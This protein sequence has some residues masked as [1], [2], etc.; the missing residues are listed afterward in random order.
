MTFQTI[1]LS[2][3]THIDLSDNILSGKLPTQIGKLS[4]LELLDLSNNL[5]EGEVSE[6]CNG[7]SDFLP[8]ALENCSS[9]RYLELFNKKLTGRLPES[10]SQ[11]QMLEIFDIS[12]NR[13]EGVVRESYFTNLTRLWYFIASMYNLALKVSQNWIP[14]FQATYMEIGGCNIGPLFPKWLQTQKQII[15]LD[16]S[17]GGIEGEVST[18]FWHLSFQFQLLNLSH[19]QFV[20]EVPFISTPSWLSGRKSPLLMYLGSNNFSGPL[21]RISTNVGE[22]DLFNNSF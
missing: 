7:M 11:L 21:P 18:W 5:F 13:L 3:L 2:S 4:K 16:I 10:L 12:D 14:P 6:L 17:N 8:S 15:S 9:L 20:G 19:N 22:L 1:S